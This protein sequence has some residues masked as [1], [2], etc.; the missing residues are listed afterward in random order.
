ML[1][2]PQKRRERRMIVRVFIVTVIISLLMAWILEQ[3]VYP[4]WKEERAKALEMFQ[5]EEPLSEEQ[6]ELWYK[7]QG[8]TLSPDSLYLLSGDIKAK[9]RREKEKQKN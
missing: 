8:G 5:K 9:E 7:H 1:P 2:S 6:K 3:K 4:Y